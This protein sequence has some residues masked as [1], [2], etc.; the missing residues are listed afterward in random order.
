[1]A[2]QMMNKPII[3]AICGKSCAGKDTLVKSLVSTISPFY[4]IEKIV[5]TTTRPKRSNEKNDVDYHF[6]SPRYFYKAFKGEFLSVAEYNKWFYGIEK[7]EIKPDKINIGIFN[8]ADLINLTHYITEY[9]IIPIYLD[10]ALEWRLKRSYKRE[11]K[12]KWEYFRRA[13]NDYKDFQDINKILNMYEYHLTIPLG[14]DDT[15][16]LP[17]YR[18]DKVVR[19]WLTYHRI[20]ELPGQKWLSL[21]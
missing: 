16:V 9:N 19:D 18:I 1:M 8:I 5:A 2:K 3:I 6:V 17:T 11:N 14:Q 13:W 21:T 20:L 12:W 4:P 7:G 15:Y 10:L